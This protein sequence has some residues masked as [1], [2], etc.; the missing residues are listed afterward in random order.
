MPCDEGGREGSKIPQSE[1]RKETSQ[2][3]SG[4][5]I[6][7]VTDF[8]IARRNS[9]ETSR[10]HEK[11]QGTIIVLRELESSREQEEILVAYAIRHSPTTW[12]PP[13]EGLPYPQL[14]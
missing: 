14:L 3:H 13:V 4:H 7:H 6:Y 5:V 10:Y 1:R 9:G 12:Q 11:V 2:V 8:H